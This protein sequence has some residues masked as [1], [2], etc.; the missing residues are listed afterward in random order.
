MGASLLYEDETAKAV[1]SQSWDL[2]PLTTQWYLQ[3]FHSFKVDL[4]VG[5][6]DERQDEDGQDEGQDVEDVWRVGQP[7]HDQHRRPEQDGRRGHTGPAL[8][9]LG[10]EPRGCLEKVVF[11]ISKWPPL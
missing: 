6:G 10:C 8:Q 3:D 1:I 9:R 5:R 7:G 4:G 2:N 11:E